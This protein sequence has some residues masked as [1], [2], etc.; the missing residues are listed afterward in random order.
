MATHN[1]TGKKGEEDAVRHLREEGYEILERNWTWGKKEVDIIA[2]HQDQII[3]VE[4]KTRSSDAFGDPSEFINIKKQRFVIRAAD[5]YLKLKNIDLE[6]RFDVI[7]VIRE[8]NET[9]IQH[10]KRAFYPLVR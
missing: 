6:T 10:I 3:V 5:A 2:K 4:V 1:E 7:S 9:R 8:P